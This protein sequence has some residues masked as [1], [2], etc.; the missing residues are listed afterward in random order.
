MLGISYAF[1]A[2][3][4][5]IFLRHSQLGR[6]HEMEHRVEVSHSHK[7]RVYGAPVFEVAHHGYVE[8]FEFALCFQYGI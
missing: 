5:Y 4:I 8:S 2:A 6:G 7:Q 1:A 3:H